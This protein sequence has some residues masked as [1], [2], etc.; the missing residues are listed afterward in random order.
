MGVFAASQKRRKKPKSRPASSSLNLFE[1]EEADS[2]AS[3]DNIPFASLGAPT[4][5]NFLMDD[6][7][8]DSEAALM[9]REND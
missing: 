8:L 2:E 1:E 3:E 6:P 4:S 9:V 5:A 7:M